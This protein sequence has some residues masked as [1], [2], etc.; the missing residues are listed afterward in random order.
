MIYYGGDILTMEGKF[1]TYVQAIAIK[2]GNIVFAGTKS[3]AE[4][5]ENEKTHMRDLK[6][7]TL[8]PGFIDAHS[9]LTMGAD[10]LNQANLNPAPV[11][12]VSNIADI[13]KALN[14]LKIRLHTKEGE[15]LVG[16]G[17]DQDFLAEKRHPTSDDLDAAFPSNPVILLHTSGHMLVANKLAL[18]L[19]KIDS[20]TENPV[21]GTIVR[22]T[23]GSNEPNGLCQ[24][25]AAMAFMP[26]L[27]KPLPI[28]L[29]IQKIVDVQDYY[30]SCGITTA[31]EGLASSEKMKI[32]NE[33]AKAKKLKI[34][35]IAL[36][37][38]S[39]ANDLVGTNKIKN[40]PK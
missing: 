10:A 2:D 35:V 5:Y 20:G 40:V 9:H 28:A 29:E 32:L 16:S 17:Y 13:I 19:A 37:M 6:G 8:I 27:S 18:K 22:K 24:E 38:F 39:L 7:K 12:N 31:N 15:W 1:P 14:D 4:L 30:I 34:D 25:M 21:G 36:P 33:T 23:D 11:G 3:E 26:F